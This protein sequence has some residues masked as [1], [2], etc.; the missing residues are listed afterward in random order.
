MDKEWKS[1]SCKLYLNSKLL[2]NPLGLRS[3]GTIY[4]TRDVIIEEV[5]VKRS[6][7]DYYNA[8]LII[9]DQLV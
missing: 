5:G 2:Y 7:L 8:S 9:I 3:K 4:R 1:N 6:D